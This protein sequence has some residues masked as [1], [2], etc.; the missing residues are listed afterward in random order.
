MGIQTRLS[1]FTN[2]KTQ[3]RLKEKKMGNRRDRATRVGAGIAAGLVAAPTMAIGSAIA[4]T[5]AG[6]A[7]PVV[8]LGAGWARVLAVSKLAKII[9]SRYRLKS[10]TALGND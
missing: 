3:K 1:E 10:R 7:A 6:V 8:I 5:A 2:F 4:A 9:H